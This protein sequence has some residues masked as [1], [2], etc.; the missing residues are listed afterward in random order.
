MGN[1]RHMSFSGFFLLHRGMRN[2]IVARSSDMRSRIDCNSMNG[3]SYLSS[4][5]IA[6]PS[7]IV[8]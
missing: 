5:T 7:S 2:I 4:T 1:A 3:L 8:A 6:E